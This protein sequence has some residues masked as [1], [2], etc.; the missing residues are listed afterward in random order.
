MNFLPVIYSSGLQIYRKIPMGV[1]HR[2][3]C[4]PQSVH[5]QCTFI[6]LKINA[7]PGISV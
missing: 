1:E 6:T 2:G 4:Y 3:T 7:Y 5:K